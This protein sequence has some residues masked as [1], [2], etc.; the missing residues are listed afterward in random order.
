[1]CIRVPQRAVETQTAWQPRVPHS[2]GLGPQVTAVTAGV[3][4]GLTVLDTC[5][6]LRSN[7]WPPP[8]QLVTLMSL[9]NSPATGGCG[10]QGVETPAPLSPYGGSG[11][12][13]RGLEQHSID[14]EPLALDCW[15]RE[16]E[17]RFG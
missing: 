16:Q 11:L 13:V 14:L 1:M 10:V 17:S 8:E 5:S 7:V 4:C 12:T 3:P 6:A 9:I 2:V 15:S